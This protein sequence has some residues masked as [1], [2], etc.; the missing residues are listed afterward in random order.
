MEGKSRDVEF[1]YEIGAMR[2]VQ[3][4]WRQFFREDMANNS[5]HT[6]RVMWIALA[7]AKKEKAK[8]EE[9]ILKMALVHDIGESRCPD[10]NYLSKNYSTRD[11][12]KAMRDMFEATSYGNEFLKLFD[13]YHERKTLEAKVVKDADLLDVDFE[14]QEHA[15]TGNTLIKD[16][17][18]KR[19][20]VYETL[21]TPTAKK[22]WQDIYKENPNAWHINGFSKYQKKK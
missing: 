17:K 16:W 5:E 12:E 2:F 9:K 6:F 1:L 4:T 13:E 14:I 8:N 21:F 15:S 18:P 7:I 20:K 22:L 3:R 11:E 19:I 10:T